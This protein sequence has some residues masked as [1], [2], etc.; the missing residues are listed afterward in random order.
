M[1][2]AALCPNSLVLFKNRPARVLQAGDSLEIELE[3]RKTLKVRPK[4]VALLHPG[5]LSD[6][7]RPASRGRRGG[8]SLGTVGRR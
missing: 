3:N 4:D 2:D 5:P 1:A 6:S 8:D 7:G